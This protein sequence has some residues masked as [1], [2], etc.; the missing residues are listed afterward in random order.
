MKTRVQWTALVGATVAVLSGCGSQGGGADPGVTGS[1]GA[2]V[3]SQPGNFGNPDIVPPSARF[4]GRSYSEWSAAYFQ[5]VYSLPLD[6][7]PLF[8]DTVD[9][10]TG[11][12]GQVW[13]IDGRLGG[14][15]PVNRSCT[16]P[17]GTALFVNLASNEEDNAACDATGTMVQLANFTE[18]E[19][20]GFASGAV[21]GFLDSR[22]QCQIDGVSVQNLPGPNPTSF[23]SPYRV[24]SPVFDYTIPA[25]DTVLSLI[26]GPCY[27]NPPAQ[28]QT[29]TGAVA[30]GYYV[31]IK[32]LPLGEHLV[33][34]GPNLNRTYHITVE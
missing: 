13:F 19:L 34:F 27:Q 10:S 9:C 17:A 2:P 3:V 25:S 15:P 33:Q 24:Q 7:H 1:A 8:D 6:N 29:V 11:Q 26:D 23:A 18:N 30:D 28:Y 20:R 16:I 5:W 31:I 14:G 22:G 12:S 21:E 4:A 32:P